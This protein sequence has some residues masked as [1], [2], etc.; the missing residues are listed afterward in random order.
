MSMSSALRPPKL[1]TVAEF[2]AWDAP[3]EERWQLV[4]G[5]PV[6]MARCRASL[7]I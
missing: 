5:E 1:M 6:A 7:D 3:G 4:D 2:I